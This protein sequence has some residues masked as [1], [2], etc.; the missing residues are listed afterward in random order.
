M[1]TIIMILDVGPDVNRYRTEVR[2][3]SLAGK[4]TLVTGP[5]RAQG[6]PHGIWCNAICPGAKADS[7]RFGE[8]P[9]G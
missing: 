3:E 6:A 5:A 7:A 2:V 1:L 8:V 9:S 4:V